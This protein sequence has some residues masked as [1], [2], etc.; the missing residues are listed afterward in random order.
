MKE[1]NNQVNYTLFSKDNKYVAALM[2][3]KCFLY[4]LQTK[5]I[6][7]HF[8]VNDRSGNKINFSDDSKLFS[9]SDY[10]NNLIIYDL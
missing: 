5:D 2:G 4:S 3:L 6:Y 8:T 9:I 7:V 10:D 1:D